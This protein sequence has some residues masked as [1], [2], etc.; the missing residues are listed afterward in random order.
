MK[1][2]R[3]PVPRFR[4][5]RRDIAEEYAD[6]VLDLAGAKQR[7]SGLIGPARPASA[8]AVLA[9]ALDDDPLVRSSE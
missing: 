9:D 1:L 2:P 5:H 7:I 3:A 6:G 4:R 8:D